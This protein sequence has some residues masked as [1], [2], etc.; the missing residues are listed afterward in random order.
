MTLIARLI[1]VGL[2]ALRVSGLSVAL[3]SR[4]GERIL[5]LTEVGIGLIMIT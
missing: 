2:T 3:G 4:T 5:L 1:I